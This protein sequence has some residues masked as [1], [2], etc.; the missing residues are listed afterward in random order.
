M[1]VLFLSVCGRKFMEF[2]SGVE[3]PVQFLNHFPI[4]YVTFHSKDIRH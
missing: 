2:W 3:V 1:K 4:A